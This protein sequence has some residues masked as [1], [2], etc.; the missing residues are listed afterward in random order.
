MGVALRV[1]VRSGKLG[2]K[3]QPIR[4]AAIG[5]L[6]SE[7]PSVRNRGA[8]RPLIA[9]F[10]FPWPVLLQASSAQVATSRRPRKHRNAC[11]CHPPWIGVAWGSSLGWHPFA[12]DRGP[13]LSW[14]RPGHGGDETLLALRRPDNGRIQLGKIKGTAEEIRQEIQRRISSSKEFNGDCNDCCAPLPHPADPATNGGCNWVVDVSR[15]VIPGC[16]D[17]VCSDF[18]KAVTRTVMADYELRE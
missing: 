13:M 14:C 7:P 2:I 11:C 5:P 17:F 15:G 8:I 6:T 4:S 12:G 18:I 10:S 16:L 1:S 9:L 3:Y